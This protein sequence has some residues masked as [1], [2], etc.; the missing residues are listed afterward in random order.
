LQLLLE[1]DLRREPPA[2]AI[3]EIASEAD[4]GV[5]A[6]LLRRDHEEEARKERRPPWAQAV[7]DQMLAT[8]RAKAPPFRWWIARLE[9]RDAGFFSSWPGIDGVGMVEDLFVQPEL[10]RRGIARALIHHAVADA[11]ARGADRVLIGAD[12][13]DWP[14]RLYADLGFAPTCIT[15]SWL[16]R[17]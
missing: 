3:R 2:I 4:W 6:G 16:K 1:G 7:T 11:R 13:N 14:K 10:R 9:D 12:P 5:L 8:K 17:D 15:W